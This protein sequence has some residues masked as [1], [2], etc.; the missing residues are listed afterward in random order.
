MSA[1]PCQSQVLKI[2]NCE[3]RNRPDVSGSIRKIFSNQKYTSFLFLQRQKVVNSQSVLS[4]QFSV[5][6][7]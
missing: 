4:Y 1:P 3:K 5:K 2:L 6:M 7:F